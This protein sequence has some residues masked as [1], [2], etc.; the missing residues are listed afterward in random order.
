[1][2]EPKGLRLRDLQERVLLSNRLET[3]QRPLWADDLLDER[4]E[5]T[6]HRATRLL[7]S[8]LE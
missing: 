5:I 7:L 2:E 4:I 8:P 1:M 3:H 6:H